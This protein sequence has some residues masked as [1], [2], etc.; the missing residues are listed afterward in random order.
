MRVLNWKMKTVFAN[1]SLKICI[2]YPNMT[3]LVPN[4]MFLGLSKS[5]VHFEFVLANNVFVK[6]IFILLFL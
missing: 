1:L 5:K 3:F 6:I 4:L 2:K